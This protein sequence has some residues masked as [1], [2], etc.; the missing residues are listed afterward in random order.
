MAAFMRALGGFPAIASK[1]YEI[2]NFLILLV[3][4][5]PDKLL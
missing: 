4:T 3:L 5:K 1:T 2:K